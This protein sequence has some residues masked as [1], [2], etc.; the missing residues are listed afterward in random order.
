MAWFTPVHRV[1]K[2]SFHLRKVMV[3]TRGTT[4]GIAVVRCLSLKLLFHR[5]C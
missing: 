3:L 5:R 1:I 2:R 4:V